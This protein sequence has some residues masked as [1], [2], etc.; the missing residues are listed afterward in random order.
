MPDNAGGDGTQEMPSG[1]MQGP[2]GSGDGTDNS[3]A[4]DGQGGPN[5]GGNGP[6]GSMNGSFGFTASGETQTIT[7]TSATVITIGTGSDSTT[8]SVTDI[9]VD[10]ILTVTLN[11]FEVTEI[12]M[13]QFESFPGGGAAPSGDTGDGSAT[14]SG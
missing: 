9:A 11:G 6:S 4:P 13:N 1:G 10:D 7:V 8:G 3:D 2:Q 14:V 12:V 5:G